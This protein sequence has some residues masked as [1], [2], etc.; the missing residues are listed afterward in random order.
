VTAAVLDPDVTAV[1]LRT[2]WLA[3]DALLRRQPAD[4]RPDTTAD[5]RPEEAAR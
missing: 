5:P 2:D 4:D 1:P 3:L